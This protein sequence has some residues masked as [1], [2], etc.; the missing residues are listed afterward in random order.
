MKEEHISCCSI[1]WSNCSKNLTP[2]QS[3]WLTDFGTNWSQETLGRSRNFCLMVIN[4]RLTLTQV[5]IPRKLADTEVQ[6]LAVPISFN[7]VLAFLSQQ[8]GHMSLQPQLQGLPPP[9][10]CTHH[11]TSHAQVPYLTVQHELQHQTPQVHKSR[12]VALLSPLLQLPAVAGQALRREGLQ[13]T[14]GQDAPDMTDGSLE[15]LLWPLRVPMQMGHCPG[16][17]RS[18]T[19]VGDK[20]QH[21]CC[22]SNFHSLTSPNMWFLP[23]NLPV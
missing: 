14:L 8:E 17:Q 1:K 7:N 9:H 23:P 3:Q 16:K 2:A 12:G 13:L 21:G 20:A 22:N 15:V 11:S 19:E 10:Q 5:S 6:G 18:I 4:W